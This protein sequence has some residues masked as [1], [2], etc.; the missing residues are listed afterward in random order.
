MAG[1][2]KTSQP[3]IKSIVFPFAKPLMAL[4]AIAGR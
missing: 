4:M 3:F 2:E 1:A